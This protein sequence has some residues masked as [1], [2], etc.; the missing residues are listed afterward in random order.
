MGRISEQTFSQRKHANGKQV[1]I[2][3]NIQ[4]KANENHGEI[5]SHQLEWLLSKRYNK[6]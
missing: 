3:I 2:I 6:C 1:C 5:I 4:G